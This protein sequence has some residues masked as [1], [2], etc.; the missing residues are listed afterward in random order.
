MKG[1]REIL[2][3]VEKLD[4]VEEQ[5]WFQPM[6]EGKWA[7]ADVISHFISWD[8]FC[9]DYRM[10]YMEKALPFPKLDVN[11][12]H[13]NKTASVY[14]RSGIT[15]KQL[16]HEY[17]QTRGMLVSILE[18]WPEETF[19]KVVK[20]G[21]QE[22]RVADYFSSHIEHDQEHIKKINDFLEKNSANSIE[23]V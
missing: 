5:M 1:K 8:R 13:V 12:D 6:S 21:S 14:A 10:P 9:M 23:T 4:S 22:I 18:E 7:I 2:E 16:I 20:L 17:D 11:V 15:K 19:H 3:W